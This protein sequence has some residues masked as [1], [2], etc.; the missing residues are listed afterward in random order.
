[1]STAVMENSFEVDKLNGNDEKK[2]EES[3]LMEVD[4]SEKF[5]DEEVK[6]ITVLNSEEEKNESNGNEEDLRH[7]KTVKVEADIKEES[8]KSDFTLNENKEF[9]FYTQDS[10]TP[11]KIDDLEREVSKDPE[12]TMDSELDHCK[13][14]E[15][16]NIVSSR[17]E[18]NLSSTDILDEI[19]SPSPFTSV[20]CKRF[21]IKKIQPEIR[22]PGE[23]SKAGFFKNFDHS[24]AP[25]QD[26]IGDYMFKTC[27]IAAEYPFLFYHHQVAMMDVARAVFY[28]GMIVMVDSKKYKVL[29]INTPYLLLIHGNE[30]PI[31]MECWKVEF[32]QALDSSEDEEDVFLWPRWVFIYRLY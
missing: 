5:K 20:V 13:K 28:P 16:L 32:C 21:C 31:Q 4:E 23:F 17:E 1:M 19:R 25:P 11:E 15:S 6:A 27:S 22:Y 2:E 26:N 7:L 24:L 10:E 8:E 9:D 3:E 18:S 30:D 29:T 14:F 12:A